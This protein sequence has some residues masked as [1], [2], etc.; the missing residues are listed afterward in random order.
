MIMLQKYF[1]ISDDFSSFVSENQAQT[2]GI[3]AA[4]HQPKT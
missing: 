1:H 3:I 2:N 4:Y